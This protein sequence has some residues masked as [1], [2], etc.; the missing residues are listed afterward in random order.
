MACLQK[1]NWQNRSKLEE[2]QVLFQE[3]IQVLIN[4]QLQCCQRA[5]CSSDKVGI[6]SYTRTPL[7]DPSSVLDWDMRTDIWGAESHYR[8]KKKTRHLLAT[9]CCA[10]FWMEGASAENSSQSFRLT[11]CNRKWFP[12]KWHNLHCWTYSLVQTQKCWETQ[13]KMLSCS[14]ERNNRPSLC[15]TATANSASAALLS[16]PGSALQRIFSSQ[17]G[18]K[19]I[20]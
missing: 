16:Q 4:L 5:W 10:S 18:L 2:L 8:K 3:S 9:D 14:L 1:P 12:G 7:K 13:G 19:Y 11:H 6:Q 20:T 17:V 15:R